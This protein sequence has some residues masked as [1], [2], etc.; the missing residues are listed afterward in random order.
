MAALGRARLEDSHFHRILDL[1]Y[2]RAHR[3]SRALK[4]RLIEAS[5]PL[6]K[7]LRAMATLLINVQEQVAAGY[8]RVLIDPGRLA[9]SKRRNAGAVASRA[10]RSLAEALE[11]SFMITGLPPADLWRRAHALAKTAREHYEPTATVIPGL[12]STL[13]KSTRSCW[14]WQPPSPRGFRPQKPPPSA[15]TSPSSRQR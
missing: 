8:E 6:G 15:S 10:L 9:H 12:S 11:T 1:F 5:L 2:D 13:K 4:A 14:R 3:L 7:E